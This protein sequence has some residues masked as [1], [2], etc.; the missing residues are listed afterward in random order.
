MEPTGRELQDKDF[1]LILP[2]QTV[3][4]DWIDHQSADDDDEWTY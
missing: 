4:I 2:K 3:S 1:P